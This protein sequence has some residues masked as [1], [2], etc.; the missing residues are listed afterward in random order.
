MNSENLGLIYAFN[1]NPVYKHMERTASV[2]P[3]IL[4]SM[5]I[6]NIQ[7]FEEKNVPQI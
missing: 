2:N 4:Q 1:K 6:M 7:I 5:I 3:K